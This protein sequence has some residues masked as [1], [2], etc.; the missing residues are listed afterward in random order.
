M[1]GRYLLELRREYR[2]GREVLRV[3]AGI[4]EIPGNSSGYFTITADLFRTEK[5]REPMACGCL[6][7]DIVEFAPPEERDRYRALIAIHLSDA[8]GAPMYALENGRY[9]LG[10]KGAEYR[11]DAVAKHYRITLAEAESLAGRFVDDRAGAAEYTDQHRA[12][13]SREATEAR[14]YLVELARQAEAAA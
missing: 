5:S 13:W 11:A 9:W 14:R 3:R 2:R 1:T 6:H 12:R 10:M 4:H 7:D 8:A